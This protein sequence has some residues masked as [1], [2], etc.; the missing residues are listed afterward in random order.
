MLGN[1]IS[2][3]E[4]YNPN[5]DLGIVAKAYNFA[6]MAHSNAQQDFRVKDILFTLIMLRSFG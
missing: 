1:I 5:A 3:I 2:Q 6:E 4:S